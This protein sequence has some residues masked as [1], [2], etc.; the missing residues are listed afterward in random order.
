VAALLVVVQRGAADLLVGGGLGDLLAGALGVARGLAQVDGGPVDGAGAQEAARAAASGGRGGRRQRLGELDDAVHAQAAVG[1]AEVFHALPFGA[2]VERVGGHVGGAAD[3]VAPLLVV[4]HAE[5][6]GRAARVL[7]GDRDVGVG[8]DGDGGVALRLPFQRPVV[9][10]AV[11][12]AHDGERGGR[13]LRGGRALAAA[14]RGLAAGRRGLDDA[15]HAEALMGHAVV[16]R[17]LV[18]HRELVGRGVRGAGD[19]GAPLGVG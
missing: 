15:L 7:H 19:V 17:V 1:H 18:G 2:A 3:V 13:G 14:F 12:V 6:V 11:G 5:V 9:D 4:A 8:L 16:R 10:A